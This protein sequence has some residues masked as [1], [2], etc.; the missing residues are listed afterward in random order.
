[1]CLGVPGQVTR[2]WEVEGTRMGAVETGGAIKEVNLE[3]VPD[4]EVGE[5]TIVHIGF[6]LQC[7]TEAEAI[8]MLG[9]FQQMVDIHGDMADPFAPPPSFEEAFPAHRGSD[10]VRGG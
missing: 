1:M 8:H 4:L 6:A 7:I 9:L 2:I 5:W 10:G 3:F